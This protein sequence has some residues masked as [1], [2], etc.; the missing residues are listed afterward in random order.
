MNI[1]QF[2]YILA[3][4]EHKHF[5][6]AAEKCFISQSTLSTMISR[7]EDEIGFKIFDR[8]K[9]PVQL[10]NEGAIIIEQLKIIANNIE[11]LKELTS[12]VKGEIKG[13]LTLSVIPTIAPFLLPIFLQDFAT[14]FPNLKIKVREETTT[15][16]IQK[17]KSRELDIGILSTPLKDNEILE[18]KLYDE[19][20]L[21]F[22]AEQVANDYITLEEIKMKNLCLMEEGH[23]MRTQVMQLCDNGDSQNGAK[24]NF[25]YK[26]GSIDSLLRFVKANKGTTLLPYLAT[27]DFSKQEKTHLS[28]FLTPIPYRSVGM[29]VHRH[30]VKKNL[31]DILQKDITKIIM[32][33]LNK[34]EIDGERLYPLI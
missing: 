1:Q 6:L 3:V 15:E 16:I 2:Q 18:I 9:K 33:I 34:M 26:A 30:F 13:S 22:D 5:E 21:F 19:P 29:V 12:I 23:C 20:F 32:P 4:A 31:L 10:T 14:K 11:Q 24:F 17:L 25:E 8:K 28:N 7:F 27:I